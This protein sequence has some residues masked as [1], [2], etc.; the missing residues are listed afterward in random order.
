MYVLLPPSLPSR[1]EGDVARFSI[2]VIRDNVKLMK[3]LDVAFVDCSQ[4]ICN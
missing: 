1:R 2:S 3:K 4:L